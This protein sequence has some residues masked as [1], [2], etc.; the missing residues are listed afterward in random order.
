MGLLE[1]APAKPPSPGMAGIQGLM[2]GAK[3]SGPPHLPFCAPVLTLRWTLLCLLIHDKTAFI[4]Q[5]AVRIQSLPL[6]LSAWNL[7]GDFTDSWPC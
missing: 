5:W 2:C 3:D 1:A 7:A 6:T 4:T